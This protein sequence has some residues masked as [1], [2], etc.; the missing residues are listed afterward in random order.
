[1]CAT[2]NSFKQGFAVRAYCHALSGA[3][4]PCPVDSQ[5]QD[6]FLFFVGQGQR[7]LLLWLPWQRRLQW[8]RLL[9]IRR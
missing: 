2:L 8:F 6:G 1:M 4:G 7:G 5:Q 3:V 9:Q